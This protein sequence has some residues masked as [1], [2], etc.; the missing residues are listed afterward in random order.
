MSLSVNVGTVPTN[1]AHS[2]NLAHL[3]DS[4]YLKFQF[5]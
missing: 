1:T 5:D 3:Y 2:M 4:H